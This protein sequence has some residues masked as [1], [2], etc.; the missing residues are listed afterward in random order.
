MSDFPPASPRDTLIERME[1]QVSRSSDRVAFTFLD[2]EGAEIATDTFAAVRERSLSV[3]RGLLAAGLRDQRVLLLVREPRDFVAA[4]LGCLYAGAVAVPVTMPSRNAGVARLVGIVKSCSPLGAVVD[5]LARG[6]LDSAEGRAALAGFRPRLVGVEEQH[7]V[8]E[9]ARTEIGPDTLAFLQYTSGSTGDPRGVMVAHS[10]LLANLQMIDD[11]F[12]IPRDGTLVSWLPLFHDMGLIGN[13]LMPIFLGVPC[14][15]M[16]PSAFAKRPLT[17]LQAISRYRASASG[18]PNVAYELCARAASDEEVAALDLRS[19]EIAFTGAEPVRAETMRRFCKRFASA[20]FASRAIHPTYGLAEATLFVTGGTPRDGLREVRVSRAELSGRGVVAAEVDGPNCQHLVGCGYPRGGT[21]LL[22]VDPQ[23]KRAVVDGVLGEIWVRG[24]SVST[25]YWQRPAQTEAT[26]GGRLDTGEGPYLRTGDLG[27]VLGGD[28]HVT[29]R[30]KDL[31]IIGGRNFYP[32]DVEQVVEASHADLG[33]QLCAAFGAEK[34]GA[35]GLVVVSEVNRGLWRQLQNEA[36]GKDLE[37]KLLECVQEAVLTELELPLSDLVLLPAGRI[38]R[39]TSGKVRRQ[40]LKRL[41]VEGGLASLQQPVGGAQASVP[42]EQLSSRIAHEIAAEVGMP[43]GLVDADRPF[44]AYGLDSLKAARVAGRLSREFNRRLSLTAFYEYRTARQLADAIVNGAL[45]LHSADGDAIAKRPGGMNLLSYPQ[46][47]LYFA[48]QLPGLGA[49]YNLSVSIHLD[50]PLEVAALAWSFEAL[51]ARHEV[52]RSRI[53]FSDGAP[54]VLVDAEAPLSLLVQD[55]ALSGQEAQREFA[56]GV[57][58]EEARRAF[59]LEREAPLRIRVLRLDAGRHVL[60]VT[61]HH[62]AVDGWSAGVLTRELS[63]LYAGRVHGRPAAL[64]APALEYGDFAAWQRG[65]KQALLYSQQLEHWTKKLAGAP[66]MLELPTDRPRQAVQ[67]HRAGVQHFTCPVELLDRLRALGVQHDASLFMLLLTAW[68]VLLW[69]HSGQRDIVVG[70]PLANRPRPELEPLVGCF[71]NTVAL[72]T[73]IQGRPS[74]VELLAKV[75]ATCL[76]AYANQDVPFELV[77]EKL[78]HG[79]DRTLSHSPLFQVMLTLQKEALLTA[80]DLEGVRVVEARREVGGAKFDLAMALEESDQGLSGELEYDAELFEADTIRR[81]AAQYLELLSSVVAAPQTSVLDLRLLPQSEAEVLERFNN[82]AIDF[83]ARGWIHEVFEGWAARTPDAVALSLDGQTMSYGEL[84]R[85]ANVLAHQLQDRGVGLDVMVGIC[86]ER[87]F[88]LVVAVLAAVKAGGAYVP[89]DPEYPAERLCFMAQDAA[90]PI[91]LCQRAFAP[92]LVGSPSQLAII[93]EF[94]LTGQDPLHSANLDVAVEGRHAAYMIYTSGST[95]RPKG[96]VNVHEAIANQLTWRQRLLELTP[97]DKVVQK[98]PIS[99][100]V[101]V[102]DLWAP[103]FAGAEMVLA[104]PGGHRDP[105]YLWDLFRATGATIVHFVPSALREF[106]AARPARGRALALRD[107]VCSGEALAPDLVGK[108]F[109]T[110]AA[111]LH[112]LYG[113]TEAAIDVSAWLCGEADAH[114]PRV[115]IGR[116]IAN[117]QLHVLDEAQR[118]VPI[119]IPGE[120]H[121]GGTGLA[122]GY[123][124]RPDLTAERFIANPLDAGRTRLYRTGDA[125]RYLPDGSL[126]FL[127]RLDT[128]VKLRGFRIEL[129]EIERSLQE[130]VAVEACAVIKGTL[131]GEAALVAFVVTRAGSTFDSADLREQLGR[132]LPSYMLPAVFV[133]VEDLPYTPSH[134]VDRKALAGLPV[135]AEGLAAQRTLLPPVGALETKV[136]QIYQQ[137]LGLHELGVTE[138]VFRLGAHSILLMRVQA[139]LRAEGVSAP[140]ADLFQRPTVRELCA[141]LEGQDSPSSL[142]PLGALDRSGDLPLSHAQEGLWFLSRLPGGSAAYNLP[143]AIELEGSLDVAA[144]AFSL[145]EVVRR[146]EVLRSRVCEREGL[147]SVVIDPWQPFPLPVE[148]LRALGTHEQDALVTARAE[149]ESTRPFDLRKDHPLRAC[150][151]RRSQDRHVLLATMHHSA[152]DGWSMTVLA[153][154]ISALYRARLRGETPALPPLGW[155]YVDFAAW[156]H[157]ELDRGSYDDQLAY[158][159]RK[160]SGLPPAVELP[161]DRPRAVN[162]RFRGTVEEV[163]FSRGLLETL[164]RYASDQDASLFMVL[165]AAWSALVKGYTSCTDLVIGTAVS[166]RPR[167]EFEPLV[168]MF[169]QTLALRLDL[170]GEPSFAELT[171]RA[172]QVSVEALSNKDIPFDVLVE[173][174]SGSAGAEAAQKRPFHMALVLQNEETLAGFTLDGVKVVSARRQPSGAKFDL[175][176]SFEETAGGLRAEFEYDADLFNPT[177]V[178]RWASQFEALV[179]AAIAERDRPVSQLASARSEEHAMLQARGHEAV[180]KEAEPWLR[181]LIAQCPDFAT[182]PVG[183]LRLL[184]EAGNLVPFGF[185]G[186][187]HLVDINGVGHRTEAVARFA[188]QSGLHRLQGAVDISAPTAAAQESHVSRVFE[189]AEN[190]VEQ[191]VM[192]VLLE[193][194]GI[195]RM[196]VTENIFV[197]GTHSMMLLRI[198]AKLEVI[199]G[200]ELPLEE[201]LTRHTVRAISAYILAHPPGPRA[202]AAESR[203]P[204]TAPAAAMSS[205]GRTFEVSLGR[206]GLE[207]GATLVLPDTEGPH[208]AAVFV[209]GSGPIDR[210]G[211]VGPNK[212]FRQLAEA[213]AARG[214]ASLRFDKR[215]Y[216]Y[217]PSPGGETTTVASD[218]LDDA[219]AALALLRAHPEIDKAG[220]FVL[221]HSLGGWVAPDVARLA[222]P[223]AGL[224]LLAPPGRPVTEVILD[225][226]RVLGILPAEQLA[227]LQAQAES[228]LAGT[229]DPTTRFLDLPVSFVRDLVERDPMGVVRALGKPTLLLRG[230]RDYQTSA[231]D[232]DAWRSRL[233][234]FNGFSAATLPGLNHLFIAG[235]GLGGPEDSRRPGPIDPEVAEQVATFVAK[236][237]PQ[238]AASRARFGPGNDQIVTITTAAQDP[239]G[240]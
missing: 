196:G 220:I 12:R 29:G 87:S 146:H 226:L 36:S 47:R 155:Q 139:R 26:F 240:I 59:D 13:M 184:D 103:L 198:V 68:Q 48:S 141:H 93:E 222:G 56:A 82:T 92:L 83:P 123:H 44:V 203:E 10:H 64:P 113:P 2:P 132:R 144:L 234:D 100:D 150:L 8:G 76:E 156:Q 186:R 176:V 180:G 189:P 34:D 194:L 33:G 46:E 16:P 136:A 219:V 86:M 213:L 169:V 51:V 212:P 90:A 57:V 111:R 168:G 229:A 120:L 70:S 161:A 197:L 153:G 145:T 187:V 65:G 200:V 174:I 178:R 11:A 55:V 211:S 3:A 45:R 237:I 32:P 232:F 109:A 227:R 122:R 215:S 238:F 142:A 23:A 221:G 24:P 43:P 81:W 191:T 20:G 35:E 110:V 236:A 165:L 88:E 58:Q 116:P 14:V 37:L 71:V 224:V 25:G 149:E 152:T 7:G 181:E 77:V 131:A 208:P 50:G 158:W 118:P 19:W 138:N 206:P 72:R 205:A 217:G 107:V 235:E 54:G 182:V 5:T 119:G 102:F 216:V 31:I 130:H 214:I 89:L 62:G 133:R 170:D 52:L 99:F 73:E 166:N 106:L 148:D 1:A 60:I 126:E 192:T 179:V 202:A 151:L 17:W 84:N 210:D 175:A 171:R 128:E 21:E 160:L 164:K 195:E 157:A 79:R 28:L 115:P 137:I 190:E 183:G 78:S 233:A 209:L 38:P 124:G 188:P 127:G 125:A 39:T 80:L 4:F 134:K 75:R 172:R 108:F 94:D 114:K 185:V 91:V 61:I 143:A 18:G 9:V 173:K 63:A 95:G 162:P 167:T 121:I 159:Q 22:I 201:F 40:E 228:I 231:M 239:I 230:Q 225:Q 49:A 199:T 129:Q 27:F 6:L 104:R 140:I 96:V 207:L 85:R 30:L 218:V 42:V 53:L 66:A 204:L 117:C 41:Y 98:T 163:V 15:L 193:I 147:P 97:G 154:E 74:F 67:S 135:T 177:T 101:S 223:I 69:R 105:A 112:N